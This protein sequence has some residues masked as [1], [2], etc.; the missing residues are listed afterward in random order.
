MDRNACSFAQLKR[1]NLFESYSSNLMRDRWS[2]IDKPLILIFVL[3]LSIRFYLMIT[4]KV[5]IENEG[6]EYARMAENFLAGKGLLSS[7]ENQ[8]NLMYAPL[9]PLLISFVTLFTRNSELAGRLV[10]VVSGGLLILPMYFIALRLYGRRTAQM[11]AGLVAL[12]PML[13]GFSNTVLTEGVYL[14][15]MMTSVYFGLRCMESESPWSC[16]LVGIFWGLA[17]VTRPEAIGLLVLTVFLVC[18][19]GFILRRRSWKIIQSSGIIIA[20]FGLIAIPYLGFLRTQTGKFILEAKSKLNYTIGTRFNSGMPY[21][22]AAWGISQDLAEEGPLRESYRYA[23]FSPYPTDLLTL[24]RY[25]ATTAMR[26]KEG[27]YQTLVSSYAGFGPFL[28]VLVFLGWFGEDWN[29]H[30][31]IAEMFLFCILI[32]MI[33]ILLS[34]HLLQFRYFLPILPLVLIWASKG[35]D[36]LSQW[37]KNTALNLTG[38]EFSEG[39]N[40]CC[41]CKLRSVLYDFTGRDKRCQ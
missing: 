12:H 25:V 38:G 29:Q 2:Q 19:S 18:V 41:C 3:G 9:Y 32:F 36:Q 1:Y 27:V 15:L 11:S 26:N 28:L 4:Q 17:Y 24:A 23:A 13:I 21:N 16:G 8:P 31:L 30:R 10:S 33:L 6:A 40:T 7:L 20:S 22:Q 14:T 5:V 34:A 37:A 39:E 35:I